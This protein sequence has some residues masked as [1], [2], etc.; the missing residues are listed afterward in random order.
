M[1]KFAVFLALNLCTFGALCDTVWLKSG[2]MLYG[3]VKLVDDDKLLLDTNYSHTISI[4]RA[5]LR[6]FSVIGP[7]EVKKGLFG[8]KQKAKKVLPGDEGTILLVLSNDEVQTF[9]LDEKFMLFLNHKKELLSEY[10]IGGHVTGGA[11]YDKGKNKT[12]Q[13]YF[14][15]QILARHDLWR[16]LLTGNMRRKTENSKS[17]TYNYTTGYTID[18]FIT[19]SFF[20]TTA[21]SY[22]RDWIEDI[23]SKFTVGSGPGYE[24]WNNELGA[25]SLAGLVNYQH[26]QYR[27]NYSNTNP[28]GTI[29]WNYYRFFISKR[30]KMFTN[31]SIG[32]SFDNSVDLELTVA[33]GVSYNF[34]R[35]F[36]IN[37]TYSKD[38]SK[39]RDGDSSSS[40]YGIGVGVNW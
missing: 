4:D 29:K 9:P 7:V 28:L 21:V 37:L 2:D 36:S 35:W 5:K 12:D 23:K 6:T 32:R 26:L 3:H 27:Q 14:D 38:K 34:T 10:L 15:G 31:G 40:N 11:Y 18:R 17:K 39:T 22:K 20:W 25:F 24:L 8:K 1:K 19:P 16:H 13:F 33:M 30:F